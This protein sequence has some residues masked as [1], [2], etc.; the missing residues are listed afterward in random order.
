MSKSLIE[1]NL[2]EAQKILEQFIADPKN[3]EAIEK[4][5]IAIVEA[6]KKGNEG[7]LIR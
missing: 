6:I 5:G 1:N 7:D 3:I 2:K 4:S